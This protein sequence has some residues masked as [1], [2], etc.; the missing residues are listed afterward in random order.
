MTSL[1]RVTA[2]CQIEVGWYAAAAA[3][4][5]RESDSA[6]VGDL[7]T[8]DNGSEH[9]DIEAGLDVLPDLVSPLLDQMIRRQ[10]L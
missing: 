2:T 3:T 5:E 7:L 4:P 1:V 10:D 6:P 9:Q 8:L